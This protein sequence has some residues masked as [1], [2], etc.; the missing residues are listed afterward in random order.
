MELWNNGIM[1]I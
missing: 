1:E